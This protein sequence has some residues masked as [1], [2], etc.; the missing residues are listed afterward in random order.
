M[1][2]WEQEEAIRNSGVYVQTRNI[3]DGRSEVS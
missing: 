3:G 1:E 2:T